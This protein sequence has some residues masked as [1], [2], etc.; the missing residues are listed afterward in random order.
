MI[1]WNQMRYGLVLLL[2]F[3]IILA[4]MI[5]VYAQV[6]IG[7][8]WEFIFTGVL[9]V[10]II[11]LASALIYF[12]AWI[13]RKLPKLFIAVFLSSGI[14]WVIILT[15]VIGSPG[16]AALISLMA[17]AVW[18]IL[19]IS[20]YKW[21]R[22]GFHIGWL[23]LVLI[24]LVINVGGIYWIISEG[25]PIDNAPLIAPEIV[26]NPGIESPAAFG[27]YA[28][29]HIYYGSGT[30]K[31]REEYSSQIT[32]A[33]GSVD[34]TEFFPVI[35]GFSAKMRKWFWGFDHTNFPLN[36]RVWYPQGDGPFP[37]VLIIH[38]NHQMEDYSDPGYQYLG[39]LLASRGYITVSVDQNFLNGS[40]SGGI[41]NE[42]DARAWILLKHLEAWEEW[43]ADSD[44]P[45]YQMVDLD[46]IALIGHSRGGE[47]AAIAARF[48]HLDYYPDNALIEFDFG[49]NIKTVIAIAPCDGQ[50]QPADQ[51]VKLA[52]INYLTI[53]GGNDAD[54]STFMG[55]YQYRRVEFTDDNLWTKAAVYI[56][57]ANHGQF[58]TTWGRK[59][60]PR[61]ASWLLNTS[62]LMDPE[63]QREIGNIYI[64]SFLELTLNDARHYRTVFLYPQTLNQWVRDARVVL[65]Y[66]DPSFNTIADFCEDVDVTTTTISG[67][68]IQTQ[69]LNTWQEMWVA[70]GQAVKLAW[71]N[72]DA[73][74]Q[75]HFPRLNEPYTDLYLVM[76]PGSDQHTAVD[77]TVE[78]SDRTG[79]KSALTLD[80]FG[81]I[82][83]RYQRTFTKASIFEKVRYKGLESEPVMQTFVLPLSVF[84]AANSDFD[85]ADLAEINFIFDRTTEGEIYLDEVGFL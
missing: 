20:I 53:H 27:S 45:F 76:A 64:S 37:L 1:G 68:V 4:G 60:L 25:S 33:T 14:F 15:M 5:G 51:P 66:L 72:P 47:A 55:Q 18:L 11:G 13:S 24:T 73:K 38:G 71:D 69:N 29:E 82:V 57:G 12:L 62:M 42:N 80:N 59:D 84:T 41:S 85:S 23:L 54:V 2:I 30:D 67:G 39:K 56:E 83:P 7:S 22:H 17:F 34:A 52:N 32:L 79:N 44:N 74:F 75:I 19:G 50:Y 65:Q 78:L 49:F 28:V 40:W 6:G 35:S 31:R 16:Y 36:G 46:N 21:H 3:T 8:I 63:I 77:F 10:I 58:N 43:N 9:A 48:N 81:V 26:Q 70:G 61:P